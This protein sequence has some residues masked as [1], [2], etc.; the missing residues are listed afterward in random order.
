MNH[1]FSYEM[2]ADQK[3]RFHLIYYDITKETPK[4]DDIPHYHRSMEFVYVAEGKFPVHIQGESRVLH[5]G[6][7]A[8]VR[9]GQGHYYTSEGDAKVFV[10]MVSTDFLENPLLNGQCLLPAF[11]TLSMIKR[12]VMSRMLYT[13]LEIWS[14][15]NSIL[16]Q[17]IFN[18]FYGLL[19]EDFLNADNDEEDLIFPIVSILEYIGEHYMEPISLKSLAAQYNYTETY[20]SSC[21]NALLNISIREY[22]NRIRIQHVNAYIEAGFTKS[23]AAVLCGYTNNNTFYRAYNKYHNETIKEM[24]DPGENYE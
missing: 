4:K 12:N 20:F 24:E 21:F 23:Q 16:D 6:E 11:M 1:D 7:V 19:A 8:Y 15:G 17:G 2:R 3:Y 14:P 22:I 10:L 5:T 13:M 9:S 18:S